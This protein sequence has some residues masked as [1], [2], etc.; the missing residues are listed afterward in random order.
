MAAGSGHGRR[1]PGAAAVE[2]MAACGRFKM[3]EKEVRAV[4]KPKYIRRLTDKYIWAVPHGLLNFLNA[5]WNKLLNEL[6]QIS[7]DCKN[8]LLPF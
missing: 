2:A 8:I 7:C 6:E 5:V 4:S 3:R 1:R